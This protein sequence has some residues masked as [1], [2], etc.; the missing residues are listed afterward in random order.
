MDRHRELR[1][2]VGN[3]KYWVNK[4]KRILKI[5]VLIT[6]NLFEASGI[7]ARIILYGDLN[8]RKFLVDVVYWPCHRFQ[9]LSRRKIQFPNQS[10]CF[11]QK[12]VLKA[13]GFG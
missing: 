11:Q 7:A 10:L 3:R 8:N 1:K 6:T 2:T 13:R 5:S 9:P 4:T 12:P